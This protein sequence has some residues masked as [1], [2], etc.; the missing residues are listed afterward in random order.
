M[1]HLTAEAAALN[2]PEE[3]LAAGEARLLADLAQITDDAWPARV[4]LYNPIDGGPTVTISFML[5]RQDEPER[6]LKAGDI[7]I[8]LGN[9]EQE[10]QHRKL[11]G[12]KWPSRN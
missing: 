2:L 1:R 4:C 9:I 10:I 12:N 3:L 5:V 7:M 8:A 11:L 6:G